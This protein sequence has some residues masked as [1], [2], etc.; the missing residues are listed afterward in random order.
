MRIG[1]TLPIGGP[2]VNP[3][4][5]SKIGQ[6]A[7]ALGFHSL[8]TYDRL[9]Y[10]IEPRNPYGG[11]TPWPEIFKYTADP[12]DTLTFIAAQTEHIALGTSVLN[13]PFYNPVLLARRLTT[14]D[15]LSNGRLKLGLGLGWSEDE[16]TAVGVPKKQRGRRM[17]EFLTLLKAIWT[18]DPVT[19]DG[20]RFA[21]TRDSAARRRASGPP[22]CSWWPT[23]PLVMESS[24]TFAP[25]AAHFIA[26]P[27]AFISQSSG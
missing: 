21:A 18:E 7:E 22:A 3:T 10:A 16:F 8:W 19:F 14:I 25:A 20:A 23:S 5:L 26:V 24:R 6:K 13:A 1:V 4:N 12:L 17:D 15:V 27:A 11:E 2:E 9:L